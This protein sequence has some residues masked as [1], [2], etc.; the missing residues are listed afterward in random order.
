MLTPVQGLGQI[1]TI[2]EAVRRITEALPT[3]QEDAL[4]E[5]FRQSSVLQERSLMVRCG[6]VAELVRRYSG[7]AKRIKST[8]WHTVATILGERTTV[9]RELYN[10]WVH[11]FS[12]LGPDEDLALPERFLQQAVRAR[13]YGKDPL[14]A[15]RYASHM[16]NVLNP[17][18]SLEEFRQDIRNGLPDPETKKERRIACYECPYYRVSYPDDILILARGKEEELRE[19]KIHEILAIGPAPETEYCEFYGI[20]G[21]PFYELRLECKGAPCTENTGCERSA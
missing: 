2:S 18:Y 10:I 5:L 1:A 4:V 20:M 9:I 11:I 7:G 17:R 8:E 14:E 15:A 12:R 3:W 21:E 13:K 6:V 16:R 19:G